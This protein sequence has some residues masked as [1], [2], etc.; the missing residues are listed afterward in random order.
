MIAL[1]RHGELI[2]PYGQSHSVSLTAVFDLTW[3]RLP[4]T[5]L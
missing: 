1:V 5:Y 3:F 2:K 4:I